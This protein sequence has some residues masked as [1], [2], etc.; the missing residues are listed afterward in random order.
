[1]SST[2]VSGP[3][4]STP[5]PLDPGTF[6]KPV[7]HPTRNLSS[8]GSPLGLV[9][10]TVGE[11]GLAY[12]VGTVGSVSDTLQYARPQP[13]VGLARLDAVLATVEA[14]KAAAKQL[15]AAAQPFVAA[16]TDDLTAA[17]NE[18]TTQAGLDPKAALTA[19]F[20]TDFPKD[21]E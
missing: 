17:R 6:P 1:M 10:W 14:V 18:R 15:P 12:L 3:S 20:A 11:V 8:K 4:S 5:P 16:F 21:F 2:V 9:C 19:I 13:A 7:I